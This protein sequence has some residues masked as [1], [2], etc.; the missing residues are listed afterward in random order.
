[1]I[2]NLVEKTHGPWRGRVWRS[3]E[4]SPEEARNRN[5]KIAVM[6]WEPQQAFT[7][8]STQSIEVANA[9]RGL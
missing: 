5:E 9:R 7:T 8:I 3:E 1:V 4:M 6:Q 2:F